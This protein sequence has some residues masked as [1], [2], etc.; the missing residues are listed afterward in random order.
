MKTRIGIAVNRAEKNRLRDLLT[1]FAKAFEDQE[2]YQSAVPSDGYLKKL[3]AREDFIPLVA[4]ADGKV[5][6]GLVAYVLQKFEQERSEIYIYDLAVL[7]E[8]RRQGIATG[9]INKLREMAREIG[10]YV[11]YVQADHGDDPAIK[12]YESLGTREDVLHF[13]IE[14]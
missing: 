8:Y 9:L 6:G 14:P 10:A 2:H 12:L 13:D 4:V 1:V 11:I 3:L 5:V 7:E